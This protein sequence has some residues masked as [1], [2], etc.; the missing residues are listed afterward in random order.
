MA[1]TRLAGA[2]AGVFSTLSAA[3]SGAE[4]RSTVSLSDVV[5]AA[6]SVSGVSVSEVAPRSLVSGVG[7]G[8]SVWIDFTE[9]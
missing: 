5:E 4:A 7:A 2:L 6:V 1:V 8:A 9:R 3:V